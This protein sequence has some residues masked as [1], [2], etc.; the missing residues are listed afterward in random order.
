M[1]ISFVVK[2]KASSVHATAHGIISFVDVV[3]YIAAKVEAGVMAFDEMIDLRD[4]NVDLSAKDLPAIA[5]EVSHALAGQTP[6]RVAVVTNSAFIYSLAQA[7]GELTH[8]IGSKMGVFYD[9]E[10]ARE[11]LM[12][13]RN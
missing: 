2:S 9:V 10:S 11:W 3:T 5:D 12:S 4:V 8:A 13:A 7:Y 1:P 6:G